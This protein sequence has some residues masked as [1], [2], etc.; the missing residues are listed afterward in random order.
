MDPEHSF[1]VSHTVTI[2]LASSLIKDGNLVISGG[3]KVFHLPP[4]IAPPGAPPSTAAPGTVSPGGG[5]QAAPDHGV[6]RLLF[7]PTGNSQDVT[8]AAGV[9]GR[10][11]VEVL[12]GTLSAVFWIRIHLIRIRIR[13]RIHL[14]RTRI[15]HV[16][17]N[18]D[19]DPD[20]FRIQGFDD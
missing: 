17:L 3:T 15:H 8:A 9:G 7:P 18:T 14:I 13:I 12:K 2:I 5:V 1:W 20:P 16:R 6:G 11:V 4:G 19:P 10:R